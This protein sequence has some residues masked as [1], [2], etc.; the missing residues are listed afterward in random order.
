M[1]ITFCT[2]LLRRWGVAL[3]QRV[4][5]GEITDSDWAGASIRCGL[6]DCL[7]NGFAG[8]FTELIRHGPQRYAP[9]PYEGSIR[10]RAL[11]IPSPA[12][13]DRC[14]WP[15]L[16]F[17][18]GDSHCTGRKATPP[19]V[20]GAGHGHVVD[21]CGASDVAV[22]PAGQLVVG[23]V[24]FDV[25]EVGDLRR[26]APAVAIMSGARSMPSTKRACWSNRQANA[27][28]RHPTSSARSQPGGTWR[29]R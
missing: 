14:G 18:R 20:V 4:R 16:L 26:P 5:L 19:G 6:D 7:E 21:A 8:L 27:P 28:A 22:A 15:Y 11:R 1:L 25:A 24:G 9:Q 12:D 13:T 29:S 10:R 3:K 23:E 17:H 2:A